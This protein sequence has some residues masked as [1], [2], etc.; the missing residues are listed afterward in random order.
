VI[1]KPIPFGKYLLLE[2][3]NVGG[4]A[5]VFVAKAS[6]PGAGVVAVKKILPTM[7]EDVEFITMFLDEARISVRL[8]HP[9]VVSVFD[10]GKVDDSFFIAMEYI[11]GRD[12]RTLQERYAQRKELMPTAQAAYLVARVCEGLDYAHS[13][14]DEKGRPLNVIH[15][16]VSPQNVLV[17]YDGRVKVI[18]FGIAKAANRSQKTQA[19]IL[20]G[21]FGYM[22]P[23]QVR[24]L[25]LD[26]RSDIFAVGV[27]LYE[28]L[29]GEKLFMGESDFSTLEKVRA[30][31]VPS[32]R[33]YNP[34]IPP[35]LE[36]VMYKALARERD[37]RYSRAGELRD[38]LLPFTGN[39]ARTYTEKT[40]A[41]FMQE[42]FAA[43]LATER[44]KL[45]GFAQLRWPEDASATLVPAARPP[46]PRART[47]T[48]EVAVDR[49][50]RRVTGAIPRPQTRQL[51]AVAAP[52]A[53]AP[54]SPATVD[55]R[56]PLTPEEL[57]EMDQGGERTVMTSR[58]IDAPPTLAP[59]AR[60]DL[61]LPEG[62]DVDRPAA[63][64]RRTASSVA[65]VRAPLPKQQLVMGSSG[66]VEPY[67]GA[68]MIGPAPSEPTLAPFSGLDSQ[69]G[70]AVVP[71]ARM[72]GLGNP[73]HP[74]RRQ[75]GMQPRTAPPK[76]ALEVT[77]DLTGELSGELPEPSVTENSVRRAVPSAPRNS[78][79]PLLLAAGAV[80]VLL[81]AGAAWFLLKRPATVP[82]QVLR[83]PVQARVMVDGVEVGAGPLALAPGPH[84]V[85]ASA[86]GHAPWSEGFELVA[87]QPFTLEVKLTPQAVQAVEAPKPAIFS[88]RFTGEAGAELTVDGVARGV[89]PVTVELEVGRLHRYSANKDGAD[90]QGTVEGQPGEMVEVALALGRPEAK[91]TPGSSPSKAAERPRLQQ[92]A[93]PPVPV[94][95]ARPP[96]R[97]E[98][99]PR[100]KPEPKPEPARVQP[101]PV[102]AASATG[103]LICSSKPAGA[104]VWVDGRNSGAVTP[105]PKAKA[106]SLAAGTHTV[107]LKSSD[108]KLKSE[109]QQ[110][111]ISEG[112]ETKLL[113]V[114]LKEQ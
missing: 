45:E 27:L 35:E 90:R 114:E 84:E 97:A 105:V 103:T 22:S 74:G 83:R 37:D 86:P 100:P 28:L 18:D 68:T 102:A 77:G 112:Q 96:P 87:G 71:S 43:E 42:A 12:L 63:P 52:E 51:P 91:A 99:A 19:G 70:P 95:P 106:L 50:A 15:R 11:S 58:D 54:T 39:G 88:A 31:H 4:M 78:R 25:T 61:A 5:E 49:P 113:N 24:G 67:S 80:G 21:K 29:T 107:V 17:G 57:A 9:N 64:R 41:G 44:S 81:V 59:A 14:S 79:A 36:R 20:K 76:A 98:P 40:L 23:E 16:D 55:L 66:E 8:S 108:G 92:K 46:Q 1:K 82:V 73:A 104:Q 26:G 62:T 47:S 72:P 56:P 85:T 53:R 60:K 93:S 32:P 101:P 38:A 75:T 33:Q 3:V 6:T 2:R 89:L 69:D 13:V 109:P 110:V 111:T 65:A 30:A 94:E 34:A 7:A 10:L 48:R